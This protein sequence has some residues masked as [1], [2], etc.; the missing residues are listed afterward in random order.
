[1][2]S[3]AWLGLQNDQPCQQKPGIRWELT[4]HRH[5]QE[6]RFA[7]AFKKHPACLSPRL[8]LYRVSPLRFLQ[9]FVWNFN[10]SNEGQRWVRVPTGGRSQSK[11]GEKRMD[12]RI[13][14]SGS[15]FR[16]HHL[17]ATWSWASYFTF[18]NLH[19]LICKM[20]TIIS[21]P[22]RVVNIKWGII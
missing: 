4:H 18:P 15:Q 11:G 13:W 7:D 12:S 17:L 8:R 19:F 9:E 1:M 2:L 10:K 22:N 16:S 5:S 21:P 3:R 6:V 14:P 20:G